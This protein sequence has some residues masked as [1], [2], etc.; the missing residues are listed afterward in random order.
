MI[1]DLQAE[2]LLMHDSCS[3]HEAT[4]GQAVRGWRVDAAMAKEELI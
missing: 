4:A 1:A 3:A 2:G